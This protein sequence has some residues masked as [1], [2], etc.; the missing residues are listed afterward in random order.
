MS[1]Q[2]HLLKIGRKRE[3]KPSVKN[4]K[5]LLRMVTELLTKVRKYYG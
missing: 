1:Y 3:T 4:G 5:N 2:I